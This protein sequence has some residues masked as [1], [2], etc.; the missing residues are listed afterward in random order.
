MIARRPGAPDALVRLALASDLPLGS[1]HG[2]RGPTRW[3]GSPNGRIIT[4]VGACTSGRSAAIA[5]YNRV[6]GRAAP[7]PESHSAWSRC[8]HECV[9]LTDRTLPLGRESALSCIANRTLPLGRC[10]HRRLA[11]IPDRTLP[12]GRFIHRCLSCIP[13]RTLLAAGVSTDG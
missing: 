12:L 3:S 4:R 9:P 13:D 7:H 5:P 11:C 8:I 10:I 6:R 2:A 1:N